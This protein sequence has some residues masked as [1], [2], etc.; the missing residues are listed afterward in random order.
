MEIVYKRNIILHLKLIVFV[1]PLYLKLFPDQTFGRSQ[2]SAIL[3]VAKSCVVADVQEVEF[4][5]RSYRWKRQA[6]DARHIRKPALALSN[7]YG[8]R[9]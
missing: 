1:R 4:E 7:W 2:V 9:T 5:E 8:R 6:D 3:K